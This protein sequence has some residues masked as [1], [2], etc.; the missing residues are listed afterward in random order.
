[1]K[2]AE[3]VDSSTR[4]FHCERLAALVEQAEV[5]Q[6]HDSRLELLLR[7]VELLLRAGDGAP[8]EGGADHCRARPAVLRFALP[9]LRKIYETLLVERQQLTKSLS[10]LDLLRSWSHRWASTTEKAAHSL[11]A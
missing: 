6:I 8:R 10:E 3:H 1:M 4:C 2:T 9:R 5:L 11:R 7:E